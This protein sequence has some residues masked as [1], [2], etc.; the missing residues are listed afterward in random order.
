MFNCM[1]QIK[2]LTNKSFRFLERFFVLCSFNGAGVDSL[3]KT[4]WTFL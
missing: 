2:F 4:I 1:C 3:K